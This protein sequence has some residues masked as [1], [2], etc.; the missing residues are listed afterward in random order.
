ML[1]SFEK[2]ATIFT[3]KQELSTENHMSITGLIRRLPLI[4][5]DD[6]WQLSLWCSLMRTRASFLR[7]IGY[8]NFLNGPI[9]RVLLLML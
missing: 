7:Y 6:I 3:R 8:L 9:S 4:G 2:G 5:I 1:G